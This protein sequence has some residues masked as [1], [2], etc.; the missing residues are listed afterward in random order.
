M[1]IKLNDGM[2]HINTVCYWVGVDLAWTLIC[3]T[4][5]DPWFHSTTW[6]IRTFF[7][8]YVLIVSCACL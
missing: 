4:L 1:T 8:L 3:V 7:I 6:M 5:T 2:D